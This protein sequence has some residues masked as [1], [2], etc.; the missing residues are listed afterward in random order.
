M[1]F[2][3]PPVLVGKLVG[4]NCARDLKFQPNTNKKLSI[5]KVNC[6]ASWKDRITC[7]LE[8]QSRHYYSFRIIEVTSSFIT[9]PMHDWFV[10]KMS[11]ESNQVILTL[12]SQPSTLIDFNHFNL[13]YLKL[14]HSSP[15]D[16]FETPESERYPTILIDSYLK[17][18][19]K[20]LS[21]IYV[22]TTVKLFYRVKPISWNWRPRSR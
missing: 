10:I 20:L 11:R 21:L 14:H 18:I 19:H 6:H 7:E 15:S 9:W 16:N 17:L 5:K 1:N 2:L 22:T 12:N 3:F 4:I 13:H 8:N